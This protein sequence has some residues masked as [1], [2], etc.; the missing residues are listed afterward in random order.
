VEVVEAGGEDGLYESFGGSVVGVWIAAA[1]GALEF[2]GPF[3]R[4]VSIWCGLDPHFTD[5]V[6]E[7]QVC[8]E[9]AVPEPAAGFVVIEEFADDV[10]AAFEIEFADGE[11]EAVLADEHAAVLRDGMPGVD[12]IE[13]F[14]R[15][16]RRLGRGVQRGVGGIG[17]A[18]L[19]DCGMQLAV[20]RTYWPDV[21][22]LPSNC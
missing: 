9:D 5:V 7:R 14:E 12:L 20:G 13:R 18:E 21:S 15:I 4:G 6:G 11:R 19:V 17:G 16:P 3:H 22:N 2:G 10:S 1:D 8:F